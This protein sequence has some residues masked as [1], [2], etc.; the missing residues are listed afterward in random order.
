[1]RLGEY[2]SAESPRT[3]R[4]SAA[5]SASTGSRCTPRA[6]D[7]GRPTLRGRAPR[8][9]DGA[10]P[11]WRRSTSPADRRCRGSRRRVASMTSFAG[12]SRPADRR[13]LSLQR[14][15]GLGR[16]L[17][18][19]RD[20]TRAS[21]SYAARGRP[22]DGLAADGRPRMREP[23]RRDVRR[24]PGGCSRC[25]R[26]RLPMPATGCRWHGSSTAGG[27]DRSLDDV[28]DFAYYATS[29]ADRVVDG[30]DTDAAAYLTSLRRSPLASYAGA[31]RVPVERRLPRWPRTAG[32]AAVRTRCRP[33]PRSRS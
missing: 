17:P 1:M 32:G 29:C 5:T 4:R 22:C 6:T 30:A 25:A 23:H 26:C 2:G 16:R 3:S 12:R 14:R 31:E 11:R 10:G 24:R 15:T 20:R 21:A 19:A 8:S 18:L 7:R 33:L 28:S 27:V 13:R 9:S